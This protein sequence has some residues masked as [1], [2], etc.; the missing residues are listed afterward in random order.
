MIQATDDM[1]NSPAI[2][3]ETAGSERCDQLANADL[4]VS[5]GYL[6]GSGRGITLVNGQLSFAV[7]L[8]HAAGDD[9]P[10]LFLS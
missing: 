2:S 1:W 8:S 4:F 7:D 9:H 10:P 3:V 6:L 5:H